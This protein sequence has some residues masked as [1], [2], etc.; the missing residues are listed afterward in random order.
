MNVVEVA[1]PVL[2]I[3]LCK[4]CSMLLVQEGRKFVLLDEDFAEHLRKINTLIDDALEMDMTIIFT[5]CE[6]CSENIEVRQKLINAI[7]RKHLR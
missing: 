3:F 6:I 4:E 1:V 7:V 5:Y 2:G